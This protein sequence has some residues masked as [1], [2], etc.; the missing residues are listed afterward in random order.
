MSETL[1]KFAK[2]H[3]HAQCIDTHIR[4]LLPDYMVELLVD[5]AAEEEVEEHLI[6]CRRCREDYLKFLGIR[7]SARHARMTRGDEER[8]GAGDAELLSRADFKE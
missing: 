5:T 8:L 2:A 1:K 3:H 6:F 7:S 4:E